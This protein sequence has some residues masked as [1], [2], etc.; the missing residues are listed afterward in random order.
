MVK[1]SELPDFDMA[2]ELKTKEDIL[3]YLNMVI[4]ENDPSELAFALG[5]I[6]KSEGMSEIAKNTTVKRPALYKALRKGASPR[7]D[8]VNQVVNA[9][10]FKITLSPVQS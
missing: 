2:E 7:F 3:I 6:A 8:T 9:L 5:V 1:I 4:E 10:G